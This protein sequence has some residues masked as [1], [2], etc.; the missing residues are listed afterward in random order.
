MQLEETMKKLVK[1]T[2]IFTALSAQAQTYVAPKLKVNKKVKQYKIHNIK[3]FE[4]YEENKYKIEEKPYSNRDIASKKDTKR[5]PSSQ[6]PSV[7]QVETYQKNVKFWPFSV[8]IN[9]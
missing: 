7:K 8:I 3:V 1:I 9:N 2:L 4:T 6:A 5:T